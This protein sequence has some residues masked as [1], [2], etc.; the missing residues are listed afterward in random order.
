MRRIA[1]RTRD[2]SSFTF[3]F[4]L[5]FIRHSVPD[6]SVLLTNRDDWLVYSALLLLVCIARLRNPDR[7]HSFYIGAFFSLYY[8]RSC[9]LLIC[10]PAKGGVKE[11]RRNGRRGI[12]LAEDERLMIE[13]TE[14]HRN[15]GFELK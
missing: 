9:F 10:I 1:S 11:G 4:N 7:C 6:D 15:R 14:G 3:L 5:S 12:S 2:R 13:R 8:S